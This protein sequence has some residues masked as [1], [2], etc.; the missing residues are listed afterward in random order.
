MPEVKDTIENTN[1]DATITEAQALNEAFGEA[2]DKLEQDQAFRDAQ[3][4]QMAS[5]LGGDDDDFDPTL[6]QPQPMTPEQEQAALEATKELLAT[7]EGAEMAAIGAITL[8]EETIQ[9]YAHEK[10][11]MS[12]KKKEIGAKR[13]APIIQKYSPQMIALFGQYKH[14]VMAEIWVGSLAY[15][16]VKQ[17]KALKAADLA[18]DKH[19]HPEK[20]AKEEQETE[21]KSEAA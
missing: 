16:S 7:P 15:G 10:F 17:V 19:L 12:D 21:Q 2:A 13:L 9:E 8:Y 1:V 20:Y 18:E 5:E 4:A 3:A 11:T 14:E 6:G